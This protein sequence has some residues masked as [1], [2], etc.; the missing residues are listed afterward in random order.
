MKFVIKKTNKTHHINKSRKNQT[1]K[2]YGFRCYICGFR[3]RKGDS[4]IDH[5]HP[6]SLGGTNDLN[7]LRPC[8]KKCNEE[9][10]DMT[11]YT[12]ETK[13]L[14]DMAISTFYKNVAIPDNILE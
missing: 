7:N 13:Y 6:V 4:T 3:L 2:K 11:I 9:K 8:C 5:I 10:N 1:Y 12:Y 14:Y